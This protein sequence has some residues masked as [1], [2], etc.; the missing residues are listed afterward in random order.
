MS[1]IVSQLLLVARLETVSIN[2]DEIVDL[3]DVTA[4]IAGSLAPL[5]L[6]TG[7]SIELDRSDEPVVIRTSTF[8]VRAA[9]GNLIENAI[10]HTPNW[11]I[12]SAA[13]HGSAFN[14]SH[15]LRRGRSV[16]TTHE[17]LRAL[18]AGR[19]KRRRCRI[20]LGHCRSN[21]EDFAGVR[22]GRGSPRWR[23]AIHTHFSTDGGRF[24][25]NSNDSTGD[26]ATLH[27]R[28]NWEL[29]QLSSEFCFRNRQS[30]QLDPKLLLDE[31]S[32]RT[33]VPAGRRRSDLHRLETKANI[34]GQ[35]A[36]ELLLSSQ[37]FYLGGATF[38]PG[39]YNADNGIAGLVELRFDRSTAGTLIKHYQLYA[40]TDGGEVWN[41][42]APKQ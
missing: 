12:C 21:Y 20:G 4:E 2:L 26:L 8:A 38:G 18:L 31:V 3:N 36:S 24:R 30:F 10:K 25:E 34:S 27:T 11:N 15:R 22:F 29:S 33:Q 7:K 17:G 41:A 42:G 40:F 16:R 28:R 32:Q 13:R 37:T 9:L 23:G 19:Q 39:Y 35:F 1:R 5:A 6:A 14:R